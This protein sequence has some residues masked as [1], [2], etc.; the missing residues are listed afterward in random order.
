[1]GHVC[2]FNKLC[3]R[4]QTWP[5]CD[6][7]GSTG[8]GVGEGVGSVKGSEGVPCWVSQAWGHE[9]LMVVCGAF[10]AAVGRGRGDESDMQRV[11]A[12]RKGGQVMQGRVHPA[13]TGCVGRGVHTTPTF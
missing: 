8:T 10:V 7:G 13:G 12:G 9:W 5:P 6:A 3:L 11:E 4:L 1:M 2:L